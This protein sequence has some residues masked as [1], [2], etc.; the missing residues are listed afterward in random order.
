ML[1]EKNFNY[2]HLRL[3]ILFL[4]LAVS[5]W[6]SPYIF[7]N[8]RF[9]GEEATH[10]LLFALQNNFFQNLFYYD[11]IAGYYN[12]IPNLFSWIASRVYLEYSPLVT[13]YGSFIFIVLL[14]YLC[15]FRKSEF[16]NSDK[17][18]IFASLILFI[19]PPFV[20][21]IWLNTLNTQV[22]LC[23]ISILIFFMIDLN[24]KQKIINHI[25]ILI[26][27]LSG[28][29]TCSL[30]PIFATKFLFNR[31]KYNLIN[32]IILSITNFLQLS[33][34]IYSKLNNT[35]NSTALDFKLDPEV[36]IHFFYNIVAKSFFARELTHFIWNK[37]FF[38]ID[39]NY[40]IFFGLLFLVFSILIFFNFKKVFF[41]VKKEKVLI[42]LSLIFLIISAVVIVGSLN[43]HLGG[44]YAAIPGSVLILIVLEIFDKTI[45]SNLKI[46]SIIFLSLSLSTG[47]Y[48][49]RPLQKNIHEHQ[50]IKFLD[51]IN[52][53]DWK[54]EIKIW[55]TNKDHIIGIWPYPRKTL[56]LSK[57]KTN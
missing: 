12:L 17:K 11:Q 48:E 24:K 30:I 42:Y 45:N 29:Y 27:G 54:S 37:L 34:I 31:S 38:I 3:I 2:K 16:L 47:S 33:L 50:Y 5:F 20:P 7:F 22:Y 23:L 36:L 44:R 52:C 15:L 8:G 9:I 14:P 56:D 21:E 25:L 53:P 1:I 4:I 10:H 39:Y 41:F 6:R 26:S 57:I 18:K 49:F 32:L 35:I 28:I 43:G 40:L 46:L 55:T 51:C 13:V 19:S